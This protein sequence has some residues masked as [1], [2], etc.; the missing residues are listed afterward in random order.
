M[1]IKRPGVGVGVIVTS[2]LHPGCVL[3][4]KRMASP[5]KG[6][7]QLPGGHLEFGET[8]EECAKREVL[9]EAGLCLKDVCFA[10]VVNAVHL[11]ESY[12]Y[13]TVLMRGEVN[14]NC[15]PEP[16]NA[17]PDKNEWWK[18]VK[19]EELPPDDELFYALARAKKNGYH[20][21]KEGFEHLTK[22]KELK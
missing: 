11:E 19:W 13:I 1:E 21:F 20:P 2:P 17:E 3:L 4:G 10:S 9:E 7:F 12:H 14:T 15:D 8:W 16:T 6:A 18:W 5:G 22:R